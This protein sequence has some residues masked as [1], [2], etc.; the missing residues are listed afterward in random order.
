VSEKKLRRLIRE[1]ILMEANFDRSKYDA[2]VDTGMK[3]LYKGV[4]TLSSEIPRYLDKTGQ[5]GARSAYFKSHNIK[6]LMELVDKI[7]TLFDKD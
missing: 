6:E 7:D 3:F 1:Q 5:G 4:N 2:L